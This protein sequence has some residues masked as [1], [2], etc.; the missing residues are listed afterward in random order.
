MWLD[1]PE[2]DE[3]PSAEEL[4]AGEDDEEDEFDEEDE[5]EDE[6]DLD[7]VAGDDEDEA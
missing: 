1:D 6:D 3:E 2:L 7:A 5:D 4:K